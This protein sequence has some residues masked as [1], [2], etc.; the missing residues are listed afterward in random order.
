MQRLLYSAVSSLFQKKH[1][2]CF[3]TFFALTVVSAQIIPVGSIDGTL[4]DSSQ[5]AVPGVKVTLTNVSTS[6]ARETVTDEQGRYFFPQIQPGNYRLESEKEGFQKTSQNVA[7]ET[8][9]K[10]T[11]DI[12]LTIGSTSETIQI[13]SEAPLIEAGSATMG[14]LINTKQVLDLPLAGRN[15]LRL[16]FLTPG[17]TTTTAP[18][19]SGM[20]DVSG[21]SYIS[22]AGANVRQNEFYID[23]V[24]NTIQD[25]VLYIPTADAVQEF[26]IQ[27]NP[28]DAEFG[29]GGGFYA[30]LTTKSG[31]NEVH[32]TLFEFLQND[33]LNANNFFL[34]RSGA[35]KAPFRLNQFG[36]T[37]GGPLIK[38]KTFWFFMYEGVR[39]S[40]GVSS[41]TTVPTADQRA[42]NFSTTFPTAGQ[43]VNIFDPASTAI[44][45]ATG[46]LRRTQFPG[47]ILPQSRIDPV[48]RNILNL[49]PQ[50]NL[51]GVGQSGA[52]NYLFVG[53]APLTTN[54]YVSRVDH[55]MGKHRLFGRFSIAK[56]LS[57][58]PHIMD[59]GS[60]DGNSRPST[61]NNRVQT[62]I[63]IGD[64]YMITPTT[65]LTVQAGFA[66]W[67]QQGLTPS[68][69]LTRL[70][71]P[72][73]F[74]SGLQESIFPTI[75][76]NGYQSGGH[77]GNWFE[78]TNTF[79]LQATVN[80]VKGAHNLKYGFQYQP[81]RNNYQLAQRPSGSYA[82]SQA[83]T[84]GP[85]PAQRG[86]A[87]GQSLASFLLGAPD[88]GSAN[89]RAAYSFQGDYYGAF[90]QDD[91]KITSRLTLN[92]GLRYELQP[93][94]TERYNRSVRG[95]DLTTPNPIENA[96]RANYAMNPSPYLP[97]DQFRVLGGQ[98]FATPEHRGN[99]GLVEKT[100]F[101]PRVGLAY[102]WGDKTVIRA[103]YGLFRSFWWQVSSATEGTGAETTTTMV[104]SRDGVTPADVLSNPFP[105]GLVQPT[106]TNEGLSTLVGSSISPFFYLKKFPYNNRWNLSIQH[107]LGRDL[108]IEVAYVGN[109]G[110]RIPMGTNGSEQNRQI[111]FLPKEYLHLRNELN[112]PVDNPFFGVITTPGPLSQRTIPLSSLLSTYP[113]FTSVNM[114]RQTEGRSYYHS[115]QTSVTKRY[116]RGIQLGATY[117][118][119]K[120]IERMRYIDVTDDG[121]SKMIGEYDRPH[122]AT[123][124]LLWELPFAKGDRFLHKMVGGWQVNAMLIYQSGGPIPLGNLLHTG[125]S[126]T[127]SRSEQSVDRWFNTDAF[128]IF[129][130]FTVRTLPNYLTGLR[131]DGQNNWD[132]SLLKTFPITQERVKL[133]FRFEMFNALNRVQFGNPTISPGA[134]TDGRIFS[135]ANAPRMLQ[136]GLKLLF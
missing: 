64:T 108:G 63:G 124:N 73:S 23:G 2:L 77:E 92:L 52:S 60:V 133:Q 75:N 131:N 121:P 122:R 18:G 69:D 4:F 105:N 103:G 95:F 48:A 21:T 120:L 35:N 7:I 100:M 96:A 130:A 1:C 27:T 118:F 33:K 8:G 45:P 30:N 65:I 81:K 34:N 93:N 94:V 19:A 32:G 41:I 59:I 46:N 128:R 86:A 70:G 104:T 136:F 116:S 114:L 61:G 91:W 84:A 54:A 12:S 113:H 88:A 6:Q 99:G 42:G 76:V 24:P 13:Q 132:L 98:I 9:R 101:V 11:L 44:D 106:S 51:P 37:V 110:M 85:D 57:I 123:V 97:V 115:L 38:D 20:T 112:T 28:L 87:V 3:L 134:D 79:S 50:A 62:S 40:S 126:P 129:P 53:T 80:H 58:S 117:T 14:S 67:T 43:Q 127:L 36:G 107:Q 135:Q 89:I 16:A 39:Q 119:S 72:A 55:T 22:T 26:N 111:H 109:T 125:T 78:H 71:Y 66:R 102:R 49:W 5:A 25:R 17:I 82:F 68:Y 90:I 56:T 74:G 47:N 10:V 31:T 83:F 15:P 29:H